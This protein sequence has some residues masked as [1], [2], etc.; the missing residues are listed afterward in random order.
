MR[1]VGGVAAVWLDA[2]PGERV[3]LSRLCL[4][5]SEYVRRDALEEKEK[6]LQEDVPQHGRHQRATE[7]PKYLQ[8]TKNIYRN[9]NVR[10]VLNTFQGVLNTGGHFGVS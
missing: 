7:V 1:A 3:N 6:A 5:P 8:K 4:V 2:L 9:N 10:D